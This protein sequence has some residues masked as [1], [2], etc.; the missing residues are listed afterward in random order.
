VLLWKTEIITTIRITTTI[1]TITIE[2]IKIITTTKITIDSK[3]SPLRYAGGFYFYNSVALH[4]T[5]F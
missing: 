2:I 3:I 1:I 5:C 4:K